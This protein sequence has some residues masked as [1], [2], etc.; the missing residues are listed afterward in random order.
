MLSNLFNSVSSQRLHLLQSIICILHVYCRF[1]FLICLI[2]H[3]KLFFVSKIHMYFLSLL[4]IPY[5]K[6]TYVLQAVCPKSH[7]TIIIYFTHSAPYMMYK[8]HMYFMP[9]APYTLCRLPLILSKKYICTSR[10][11][12]IIPDKKKTYVPHAVSPSSQVKKKQH[13]YLT[14]SVHH[15]R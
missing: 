3:N 15:P 11:Q 8:I 5:T 9:S 1:L 12:S 6:N 7:V 4:L 2:F 14:Q 13:M 10:S